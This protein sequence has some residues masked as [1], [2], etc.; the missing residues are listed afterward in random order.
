MV[1]TQR[2]LGLAAQPLFTK[3]HIKSWHPYGSRTP[4][5]LPT[6]SLAAASCPMRCIHLLDTPAAASAATQAVDQRENRSAAALAV[7]S[8]SHGMSG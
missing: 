6:A 1:G 5:S 3:K 7:C 2:R 4:W 8:R